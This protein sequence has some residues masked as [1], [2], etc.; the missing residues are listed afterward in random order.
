MQLRNTFR[1]LHM[2]ALAA[3]S[4]AALLA[5]QAQGN[6][7]TGNTQSNATMQENRA[8]G[9]STTGQDMRQQ[10]S[11]A[12]N[13]TAP[14]D[15]IPVAPG[16]AGALDMRASRLIGMSVHNL[17]GRDLG[18]INDLMIDVNN[19]RVRYAILAFG[20]F[21][22]MGE[23]LFA[24]PAGVLQTSGNRLLLDGPQDRLEQA[25]GFER[26]LWPDW[27]D[28]SYREN[29][30]RHFGPGVSGPENLK[31]VRLVRATELMD[32]DIN[33]TQGREAG[34]IEDLVVNLG[35]GEVRYA[36][37]DFD[38]GWGTEDKLLP[39]PLNTLRI[40]ADDNDEAV[41]Q[42]PRDRLSTASGFDKERWP[43]LNSAQY[44]QRVD[45][46]FPRYHSW[47]RDTREGS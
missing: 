10:S 40:P 19:Q 42:V 15:Q 30:D 24:Y 33:D 41:L 22:G 44:R 47:A 23:K 9:Q 18:E 17:Q 21:M 4:S 31:N 46:D 26:N 32:M 2:T 29:V 1:P 11:A 20:G 45:R 25:P 27:L 12:Q 8:S 28:T 43:D 5:G 7:T 3:I 14:R 36:V 6:T 16:N 39:L 35:T 38:S 13:Q 34:E 37:L